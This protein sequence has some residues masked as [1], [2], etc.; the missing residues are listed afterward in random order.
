M[1]PRP[2]SR[3]QRDAARTRAE[4]LR[5]AT[6]EFAARGYAGARV[7][8]IAAR[9]STTKRMIYYYF[10]GKEQLY[11]AVLERAYA[12][13]RE[14]EQSLDVEHLQPAAAIRQLAQ[15]T[16]DHH[17]SNPEFIRL[18][19]G[20]NIAGA[21]HMAK[22]DALSRIS[23]PVVDQISEVLERGHREG[24]F[25]RLV[26]PL[27]LHMLISSFCVFRVSNRHTFQTIFGRDLTSEDS[28]ERYR[29]MLGDVV[30]DYL[31]GGG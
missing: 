19:S 21:R 7:D 14:A 9:T 22:S 4:I 27:D 1:A 20:E 13:I 30:I 12:S 16:F 2:S 23:A 29:Q 15:L 28:R 18:V 6:S 25:R 24:V 8:E 10:G 3:P 26:D 5:V 17:E 31:Q 11:I